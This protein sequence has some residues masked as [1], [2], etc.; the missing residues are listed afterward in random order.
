MQCK[1]GRITDYTTESTVREES[2]KDQAG[3]ADEIKLN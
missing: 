1:H 2:V 3:L